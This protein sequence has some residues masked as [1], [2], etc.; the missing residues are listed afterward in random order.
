MNGNFCEKQ[1]Y[2]QEIGLCEHVCEVAAQEVRRT[3]KPYFM[4]TGLHSN[5]SVTHEPFE[6]PSLEEWKEQGIKE[7]FSILGCSQ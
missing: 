2:R 5:Y 6:Y 3:I 7:K 4:Q 1:T